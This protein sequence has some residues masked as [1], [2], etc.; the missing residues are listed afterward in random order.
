MINY[1]PTNNNIQNNYPDY[2]PPKI[3]G[4]KKQFPVEIPRGETTQEAP[5]TR[6]TGEEITETQV[7]TGEEIIGLGYSGEETTERPKSNRS[8]RYTD[9]EKSKSF[10]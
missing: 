9:S 8:K 5:V 10:P 4:Y 6:S 3:K 7:P 1:R 2:E